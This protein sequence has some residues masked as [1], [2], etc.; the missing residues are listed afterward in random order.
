MEMKKFLFNQNLQVY[1]KEVI[2]FQQQ[3]DAQKGKNT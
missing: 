3:S 2:L 1:K